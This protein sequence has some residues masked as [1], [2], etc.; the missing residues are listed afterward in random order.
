MV[1]VPSPTPPMRLSALLTHVEPAP[2]TV[3]MPVDPASSPTRPVVLVLVL[4]PATVI[5]PVAPLVLPT[6]S[7]PVWV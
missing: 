7:I 4:P 1:S 6:F 2:V 5:V 3:T